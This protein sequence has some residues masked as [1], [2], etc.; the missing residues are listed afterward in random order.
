MKR[1]SAIVLL[2]A[3]VVVFA[4]VTPGMLATTTAAQGS[5]EDGR[6]GGSRGPQVSVGPNPDGSHS[7][8]VENVGANQTIRVQFRYRAA[9]PDSGLRMREMAVRTNRSGDYRFTLRTS[10]N[11]SAGVPRFTGPTPFGYFNITHRFPNENVTNASLTFTLNRTRLRERNVSADR[12]ALHRYDA[13]NQTWDRLRTRITDRNATHIAFRSESPGLSEFAVAPT[14]ADG[15]G[16]SPH[17]PNVSVGPN[18]NGSHSVQVENVGANQTIRVQFRYRAESPD[19]GVRMQEMA[20]R[21][22]QRGDYQFTLRTAQNASAGVRRF[23]GPAP[24][25][26]FNITHQFSNDNVTNASLTFLL[27]RTRLRERNVSADQVALYR[28]TA[29][30]QTWTRLRTQIQTQNATHVRYR[31]ESPGLSE[32]AVAATADTP[33]VTATETSEPPETETTSTGTPGFS[34]GITVFALIVFL[35]RVWLR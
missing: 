19:V 16:M 30:N 4:S 22:N 12:V 14:M 5:Q 31:A 8:R 27:N 28:Y 6:D 25:S 24:F 3:F 20:V 26:Y 35:G 10:R 7:M 18:P 13:Q 32:F 2:T 15:R 1:S 11:V 34:V 17:G 9:S 29:Q 21:T 33:T 23:T